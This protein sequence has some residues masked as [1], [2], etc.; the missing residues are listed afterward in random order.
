MIIVC[1]LS[2]LPKA[3][4]E[5]RPAGVITLLGSDLMIQQISTLDAEQHLRLEMDDISEPRRG[6]VLPDHG[7]LE[8][9]LS[10]VAKWDQSAGPLI[11]HCWAGIS[12][13]TASALIAQ[14]HLHPDA[15][16]FALASALRDIAPHA[17]PNRR[18]IAL[19]DDVLGR[20]GRLKEAAKS[21]YTATTVY[22]GVRFKYPLHGNR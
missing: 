15:D 2:D 19:A 3:I 11:V 10:F 20:S 6:E 22:E 4:R 9:L 21:V 8:Q 14:A 16:E 18:L 7:H 1:P 13:S 17:K 5:E 12:R